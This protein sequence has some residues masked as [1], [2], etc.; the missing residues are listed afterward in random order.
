MLARILSSRFA[1][2]FRASTDRRVDRARQASAG[3]FFRDPLWALPK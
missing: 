2:A 1:D 3:R